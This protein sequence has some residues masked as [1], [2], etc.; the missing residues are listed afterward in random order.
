MVVMVKKVGG[1]MAVVIPRAIA[2]ELEL[3]EGT[4]LDVSTTAQSLV[5]RKRTRRPRR[6]LA[7]IVAGIK[8]AAYR[9]RTRALNDDGGGAVGR[10]AW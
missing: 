7:E 3:S 1:S 8:P 5:M 6:R 10:E 4:A 9:R 2:R